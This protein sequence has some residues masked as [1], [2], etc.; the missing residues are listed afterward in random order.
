MDANARPAIVLDNVSKR[1]P[2]YSSPRHRLRDLLLR[3]SA[4]EH[5]ALRDVDLEV[6]PGETVGIVGG[7]GAGKSTL[8][9]LVAGATAATR[10][11][12]RAEGRVAALLELGA[13][14][15]PDWTGRQNSEFHMRLRGASRREALALVD[16]VEDFADIGEYFD[17]PLR[18]CSS[19]MAMRIAFAAAVAIEPDIVLVDEA[20]AVGDASFQHKCFKRL[21]EFQAHGV[22]TLLVT[23][24]LDLIPQLC[25]RAILLDGGRIAFDGPPGQAVARYVDLL[26]SGG[27]AAGEP[28][29]E[30]LES[31][32]GTGEAEIESVRVRN[33]RGEESLAFSAGEAASFAVTIRFRDPIERPLLGFSLRTVENVVLYSVNSDMLARP[34]AAAAAGE[35]REVRIDCSLPLPAGSVFADFTVATATG[36]DP[37]FL[38]ARMSMLRLEVRSDRSFGGLID[39]GATLSTG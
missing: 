13:G 24:R 19:G 21:A 10:G 22:T 5:W 20:L 27:R 25:G 9:A 32:T 3:R 23:H 26:L 37:R 17:Q 34:L 12:V 8:L 4:G 28:D 7:N 29:P 1:Y 30:G 38:D 35:R 16:S 39:L 2:L 18:A 11:S 36:A 14:F 33:S 15:H 31:R 6:A